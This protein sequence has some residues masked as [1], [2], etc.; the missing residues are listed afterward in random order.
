MKVCR[1]SQSYGSH[2]VTLIEMLVYFALLFAVMACVTA[3][4]FQCW[5]DSR[6]LH[7]N[8]TDILQALHGGDQ[9]RADVRAATGPVKLT[10]TTNGEQLR[11]A[12][13]KGDVVY[14]LV[15][16]ELRRQAPGDS[17]S[18]VWLDHVKSSHMEPDP[19]SNIAALRWELEWQSS[20]RTAKFHPLF[21]F[22]A[23]LGGANTP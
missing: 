12:T 16:G 17:V 4:F 19:R 21:T 18:R 8:A 2:G 20:R 1:H 22:E 13:S 6:A 9:W 23:V 15:N 7:R 10:D 5:N 3:A 11:V 14:T